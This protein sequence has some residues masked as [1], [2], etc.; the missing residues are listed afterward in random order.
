[1]VI[2]R[3]NFQ[4]R[5]RFLNDACATGPLSILVPRLFGGVKGCSMSGAISCRCR[6]YQLID[7][8]SLL[9]K[10]LR[11]RTEIRKMIWLIS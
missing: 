4:Y 1:M 3:G 5:S 9:F 6:S 11:L 7:K 10:F 2:S 8:S